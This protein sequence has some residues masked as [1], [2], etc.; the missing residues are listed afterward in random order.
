MEKTVQL[1]KHQVKS[2]EYTTNHARRKLDRDKFAEQASMIRIMIISE[3]VS[4]FVSF[5]E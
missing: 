5:Y 3:D 2:G 1:I 4:Q